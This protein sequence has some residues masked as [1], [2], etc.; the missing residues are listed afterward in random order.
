MIRALTRPR[1]EQL[2]A[3]AKTTRLIVFGDLILDEFLWGTVE[4]ISPEAP[5]P[6]VQVERESAMPGGAA[7]VAA[8]VA[9]LGGQPFLIGVVGD[10]PAGHRLRGLLNEQGLETSGIQVDRSRPTTIKTRVVAHHQQVV[11]IDR[12]RAAPVDHGMGALC[13]TALTGELA[14]AQ[15]II[16]EDYGKGV[17]TPALIRRVVAAARRARRVITVDPKQEHVAYYRGVT[18]LTPNRAEAARAAGLRITD[19][20]SLRQAGRRLMQRL[21]P[22]SLLV[23]LGEG[24]MALFERGGRV[25]E[26]PTVAREVFDVSGAGDTVIAVFTLLRAAGAT[27]RE[28]AVIAN[29]A[30]GVVV[31][32]VGTAVCTPRELLAQLVRVKGPG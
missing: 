17:V 13:L 22:E 15:G 2:L 28:A 7:N 4:R 29:A 30:A 24:G 12:E 11:R 10:D 16:I 6:V 19:R 8:N 27:S 9:A 20:A 18:A 31:G 26:I 14:A 23:T 3:A 25:T 5:V 32:K 1:V 21:R